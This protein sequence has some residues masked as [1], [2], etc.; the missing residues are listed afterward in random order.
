MYTNFQLDKNKLRF[1]FLNVC[2]ITN[3]MLPT[4]YFLPHRTISSP[5]TWKMRQKEFEPSEVFVCHALSLSLSLSLSVSLCLCCAPS[6]SSGFGEGTRWTVWGLVLSNDPN[7]KRGIVCLMSH[8]MRRVQLQ[9]V[10]EQLV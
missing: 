2:G 8:K 5:V 1:F 4:S 9:R 3:D 6:L 7:L 10:V